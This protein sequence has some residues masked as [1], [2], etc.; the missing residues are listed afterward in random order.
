MNCQ[1]ARKLVHLFVDGALDPRANVDVLAHVNMCSACNDRFADAKRFEDFLK[2][3]LK[4]S[5]VPESVKS[6]IEFRLNEMCTPF[7]LR[8]AGSL[9]RKPAV[10]ML[11]V[12]ALLALSFA[13][14]RTY[15]RMGTCPFVVD[16]TKFTKQIES[17]DVSTAPEN[18]QGQMKKT[19][20]QAGPIPKLPGMIANGGYVFS[21]GPSGRDTYACSFRMDNCAEDAHCLVLYFVDFPGLKLEDHNCIVKHGKK[22]CCWEYDDCRVVSWKDETRGLYCLMVCQKKEMEHE[23]LVNFASVAATR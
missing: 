4:P 1:E 18:P 5:A 9:R 19:V 21:M 22:F 16:A 12:A 6:K 13:S 2:E 17:G 14:L 10:A 8:L 7:P 20:E 15:E 23:S 11:G 3:K